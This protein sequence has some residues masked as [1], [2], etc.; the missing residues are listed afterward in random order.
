[1]KPLV[2]GDRKEKAAARANARTASSSFEV[3][4]N[5]NGEKIADDDDLILTK[6]AYR[7]FR[8]DESDI[9]AEVADAEFDALRISQDSAYDRPCGKQRVR[10][11]DPNG[12]ISRY[13]A[14]QSRKGRDI[15]KE[16]DPDDFDRRRR[17]I[18][19][20]QLRGSNGQQPDDA[21]TVPPRY[22]ATT[23]P[24]APPPAPQNAWRKRPA[25]IPDDVSAAGSSRS[26]G[27]QAAE[28][29][30]AALE[31]PSKKKKRLPGEGANFLIARDELAAEVGELL[32]GL[33]G[34]NA[35]ATKAKLTKATGDLQRR[36]G[37]EDGCPHSSSDLFREIN[38]TIDALQSLE[39]NVRNSNEKN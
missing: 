10:V 25:E 5:L 11:Q 36:E 34:K 3:A 23:P 8:T 32:L 29:A 17:E 26:T 28:A 7:R 19:G 20:V 35:G 37:N 30:A 38:E 14:K 4:E 24:V 2:F 12:R 15:V 9:E 31:T 33:D 1:M 22:R 13:T 6:S 39:T 16:R 27:K 21:M 18:L